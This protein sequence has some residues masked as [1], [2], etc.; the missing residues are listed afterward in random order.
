M[1]IVILLVGN[2]LNSSRQHARKPLVNKE[3][4]PESLIN[5]DFFNTF[6]R[7]FK[8]EKLT[9]PCLPDVALKL[10][11]AIQKNIGVEE[12]VKIINFDSVISSKLIQIVNSPLYR[13]V[14][15]ITNCHDAVSRLGLEVTRNLVTSISLQNLYKSKNKII[16]QHIH[17]QW[18]K[19]IQIASISYTLAKETGKVNPDEALLMG[20]THNI[21]AL[22]ILIFADG[23]ADNEY[24]NEELEQTIFTLQ[25][26][27]GSLILNSWD[28]PEHLQKTPEKVEG[29]FSNNQEELD[30]SDIVLLAKFHSW[31]G[32]NQQQKLP[33]IHTLPAFQKL[34]ENQ[35]TPDLSLKTLQDAKQQIA[36]TMSLFK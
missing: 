26:V 15:P 35:L 31:L 21:G 19:S 25:G 20:L 16:A 17:K 6:C 1:D 30:I 33:P 14:N 36:Q 2:I 22:P 28:F 34:G 7:C 12:A 27:I 3:D 18:V 4:I 5:S 10:R 24:S 29:W 11:A 9:I 13:A 32:S 23:L 8:E